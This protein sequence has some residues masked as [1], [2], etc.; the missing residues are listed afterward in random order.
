MI[1]LVKIFLF[2]AATTAYHQRV[3]GLRH[4]PLLY[5]FQFT[6]RPLSLHLPLRF[7]NPEARSAVEDDEHHGRGQGNNQEAK[8]PDPVLGEPE[9]CCSFN[10]VAYWGAGLS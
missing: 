9:I 7:L 4:L 6:I 10:L 8:N 5:V 2:S 3:R 1:T